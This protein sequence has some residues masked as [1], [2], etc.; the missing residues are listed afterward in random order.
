MVNLQENVLAHNGTD[1][2]D[3]IPAVPFWVAIVRAFQFVCDFAFLLQKGPTPA[4][5]L[6]YS[7]ASLTSRLS[8][9]CIRCV[10]VWRR[11]RKFFAE[12]PPKN[13]VILTLSSV[14]W[15]W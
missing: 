5:E 8:S 15:L 7:I 3:H 4:S 13:E 2:R 12:N 11:L 10:R 9:L 14:P 1:G 6:T